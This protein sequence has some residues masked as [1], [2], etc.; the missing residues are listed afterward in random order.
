MNDHEPSGTPTGAAPA[1]EPI[2][3]PSVALVLDRL[4]AQYGSPR[5]RPVESA[6][7]ELVGTILSQNT[8]D[9]NTARAFA[10]LWARFGAW[11]AILAAPVAAIADA[12][13][14]GGLAEI[15]APRIKGVLAAIQAE[16]GALDLEFLRTWSVDDARRYLTSLNG[17]GP[18]TA[19]CVLLFA[20]QMPAMPVD[21]H[22]HRVS[23]RLGLI[24][25]R[26]SAEA[27][28][29]I[30]EAAVPGRLMFDAHMLLIQHG[31][32]ICKAQR[33]RCG[34][35]PLADSCPRVGVDS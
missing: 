23:R 20:L 33:P 29:Q 30:L 34:A 31:R 26:V 22:V 19:A 24:G 4:R 8:S 7:A 3:A 9:T 11:E 5:P 15:K 1:A 12:I 10:G 21:T 13:R 14:S 17:V 16:H 32:T 35:C 27:A 2:G 25:P 28:H 18:K 6:L